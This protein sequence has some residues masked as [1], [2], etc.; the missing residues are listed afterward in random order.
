MKG[1]FLLLLLA[2]Q[3]AFAQEF[4]Y[5]TLQAG[6]PG[7]SFSIEVSASVNRRSI[8]IHKEGSYQN[9]VMIPGE[10]DSYQ[11]RSG[12]N[13]YSIASEHNALYPTKAGR[14]EKLEYRHYPVLTRLDRVS[15]AS[16]A[17]TERGRRPEPRG[18]LPA[19]SRGRSSRSPSRGRGGNSPRGKPQA[20]AFSPPS[21]PSSSMR[22]PISLEPPCLRTLTMKMLSLFTI[23]GG[24]RLPS[25]STEITG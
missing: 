10:F 18:G 16:V 11:F 3:T 12:R 4:R 13:Q 20:S 17:P 25:T 8:T 21:V 23:D 19:P 22:T 6:K 15:L 7:P 2:A 24:R 9:L 1:L 14:T 5:Q